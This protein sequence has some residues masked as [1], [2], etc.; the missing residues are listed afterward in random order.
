VEQTKPFK[1]LILADSPAVET[2]FGRVVRSL[3]TRWAAS[4]FFP[5]GITV[6]GIGHTGS[7]HTLPCEIHMAGGATPQNHWASQ[8]RLQKFLNL[9]GS[10]GYTH[11]WILQDTFQLCGQDFPEALRTTC[12]SGGIRSLFYFPVDAPLDLAWCELLRAVD[13]P[14]AYTA[15]GAE[16]VRR[17]M[18]EAAPGA[19]E[20]LPHGVDRVTFHPVKD[21]AAL[22]REIFGDWLTGLDG[23]EPVLLLNVNQLQ[24]RKGVHHSL[25]LLAALKRKAP[26]IPWRL[27]LH[28]AVENRDAGVDLRQ[29]AAQ[30]GLEYGVDWRCSGVERPEAFINGWLPSV[31]EECL[32]GLYN[33]A[34][35]TLSTSLGEGWGLSLTESLAAG[36]PVLAP[37]H[38]ACRAVALEFAALGMVGAI[39]PLPLSDTCSV[40]DLDNSR[41]R[42]PVDV[43]AAAELLAA[44]LC[45]LPRV[46]WTPAAC[47]WLDWDRIAAEWLA[48]FA[49]PPVPNVEYLELRTLADWFTHGKVLDALPPGHRAIVRSPEPDLLEFYAAHPLAM[50]FQIDV[51]PL[52]RDGRDLRACTAW[53]PKWGPPEAHPPEA[54]RAAL[55]TFAEQSLGNPY[56]VVEPSLPAS[57]YETLLAHRC[58]DERLELV[59]ACAAGATAPANGLPVL[60][61]TLP[62]LVQLVR[63]SLGAITLPGRLAEATRLSGRPQLLLSPGRSAPDVYRCPPDKLDAAILARF[64]RLACPWLQLQPIN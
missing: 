17:V 37:D 61:L 62:G 30:F 24:R 13:V 19:L 11:V 60:Q 38:T 52:P 35:W 63:G 55:R 56:I 9:L 53:L 3:V 58:E 1:L 27:Y 28:M 34:D 20:V 6:W 39:E 5:G 51:K 31:T 33:A 23:V 25:Q 59:I 8:S 47:G 15:Q 32:N 41:V 18:G 49:A 48:L 40:S 12:R 7:P 45:A 44:G 57:V 2:G 64:F 4:G 21:R 46:E 26:H 16:E 43:E 22:R 10:G 29:V 36:T 54:D 42:W 14:V 50:R